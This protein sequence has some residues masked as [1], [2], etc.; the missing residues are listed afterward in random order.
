MRQ[1]IQK[2]RSLFWRGHLHLVVRQAVVAAH[3]AQAPERSIAFFGDSRVE[4]ALLPA[5]LNGLTVVN[6]GIGSATVG[7][8]AR[9]LPSLLNGKKLAA[10]VVSVGINNSKVVQT[11]NEDFAQSLSAICR[12]LENHSD[13]VV[14][15]TI[16]PA[17]ADAPL[18]LGYFDATKI[19]ANNRTIQS[20]AQEH[21]LTVIDLI[22]PMS[23]KTGALR[24]GYSIDG[25]HFTPDGYSS[26]R[27]AI[28]AKLKELG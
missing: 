2:L 22:S 18:G 1:I 9:I 19:D 8:L 24:V 11:A 15:T 17:L 26:W 10:S 16:P 4:Q 12:Y 3:I 23:D 21:G 25:V 28:N 13:R 5:E 27:D 20:V 7:L 14:L 6:A